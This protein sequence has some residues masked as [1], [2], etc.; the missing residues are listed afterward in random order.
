MLHKEFINQISSVVESP[1]EKCVPLSGGD[2]NY[3][4]KI[5][6]PTQNWVIK[7]N[8]KDS[9]PG[10]FKSEFNGLNELYKTNSIR[11]A[12]P[13]MEGEYENKAF[14]ILEYIAQGQKTGRFWEK[15]GNDLANLHQNTKANFGFKEDNYIGSLKQLNS[16]HSNWTEFY[17]LQRLEPQ[18]KLAVNS[19]HLKGHTAR[20]EKL[21]DKLDNLFPT[22]PPAL[23][24][25]D[26][27][28]GNFIAGTNDTPFLIDPAIYYGHREMDIG[29]MHLFGGFDPILFENYNDVNPL[30]QDW[31]KRLPLTQLY[32]LMVHVNLFGEGYVN[33]VKSVLQKFT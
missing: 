26:L 27:W 5:S 28:S 32:P 1:I 16:Q 24:H 25:G 21:Y 15:F 30:E 33:S 9:F 13:I 10:M 14:L 12:K 18:L 8:N 3:V 22:E 20:F 6:T 11:V 29:M 4:Y 19:G 23:L 31:Q 7:V 2:I 17:A